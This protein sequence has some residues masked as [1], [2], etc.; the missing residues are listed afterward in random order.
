MLTN[1]TKKEKLIE[2]K[3]GV[4]MQ[5]LRNKKSQL[6]QK[7]PIQELAVFGS[8]GRDEATAQSD[9][10]ILVTFREPV[11][12]EFIWLSQDLSD[13]LGKKVDLVSQNTL[14]EYYWNSIKNDL[15]YV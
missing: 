11:G 2:A 14:K 9:V 12:M 4:V 13:F 1:R 3:L 10:D 15:N 5:I 8:V 6:F 7:Y